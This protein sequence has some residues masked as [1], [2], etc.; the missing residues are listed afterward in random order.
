MGRFTAGVI[1]GVLIGA[2]A[3]VYFALRES[4]VREGMEKKAEE[5]AAEKTA[6]LR[7]RVAALEDE[8]EA[9]AKECAAVR[10]ELERERAAVASAGEEAAALKERVA[11]LEKENAALKKKLA[12]S[13]ARATQPAPADEAVQKRM[14]TLQK[15]VWEGLVI[16]ESLPEK[17][18]EDL[19]VT[20][21]EKRI[22]E[23]ALKDEKARMRQALLEFME[24]DMERDVSGLKGKS[25]A[26]VMAA[27]FDEKMMAEL[28]T[29]YQERLKPEEMR[30][31]LKGEKDLLEMLGRDSFLAK[32]GYRLWKQ[33]KRTLSDLERD[34][35][36]EA[37]RKLREVYLRG[38]VFIFPPRS[39]LSYAG[40][41]F[42]KMD[43]NR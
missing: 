32:L 10:K 25:D 15:A 11:A 42:T 41:D 17:V 7:E 12:E 22:L 35:S 43:E 33:R 4:Y 37:M 16:G 5:K 34:M 19:G 18:V 36:P 24:K 30:K 29:F 23:E 8:L 38:D 21:V 31:V 27:L 26:E 1:V 40:A 13:E 39:A 9:K 6:T 2:F 3:S 14:K 20:D 28:K